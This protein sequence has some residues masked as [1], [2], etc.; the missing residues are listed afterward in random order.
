MKHLM[1]LSVLLFT[2][3]TLAGAETIVLKAGH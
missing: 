1:L 3:S 2:V